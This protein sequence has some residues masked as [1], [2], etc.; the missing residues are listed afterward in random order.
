MNRASYVLVVDDEAPIRHVLRRWLEDWD[1]A[2][3]DKAPVTVRRY[4]AL[5]ADPRSA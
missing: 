3:G 1:C 2:V 4:A 5:T